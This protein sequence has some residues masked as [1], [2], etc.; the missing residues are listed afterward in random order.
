M[1]STW[2]KPAKFFLNQKAKSYKY[3]SK[4]LKG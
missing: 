3:N 4:A 1:V 2:G